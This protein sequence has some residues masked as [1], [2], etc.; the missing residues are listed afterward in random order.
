MKNL[1]ILFLCVFFF[2]C[3]NENSRVEVKPLTANEIVNKSITVSGGD[4]FKNALIEFNFR[5]KSYRA[6]RNN[7]K[8]KFEREFDDSEGYINDVIDNNGFTRFING[9]VS[10][11]TDDKKQSYIASVNSVHYFSV[12]PYGLNDKAVNKKLIGEEQIKNKNYYKIEVT[13]N[14]EGGGEDYEDVFIYWI[15]KTSYKP[16]Y[17]AYS[18]NEDDGKGRRFRESYN[19]RYING[20]RFVDYNN[21]KETDQFF[22]L[23]NLGKAFNENSLKL[24][25]KIELE[26]VN[27]DLINN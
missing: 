20:L 26:N 27:V 12:L 14:K 5:D 15:N 9:E 6:K 2:N 18:Y 24:L 19:E 4:T 23:N 3:K 21:Y 13:F 1:Y 11:V 17:L 8:F 7:G 25:S 16:D 10:S 22:G